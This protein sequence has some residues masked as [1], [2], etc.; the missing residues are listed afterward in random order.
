MKYYQ[1]EYDEERWDAYDFY[2]W[3]VF[4]TKEKAK[5]VFPSLRI[6]EY[7]GND[8]EDYDLVDNIY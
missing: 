3:F 2:S 5:E 7:E 8:I 6:D 1:P 4:K